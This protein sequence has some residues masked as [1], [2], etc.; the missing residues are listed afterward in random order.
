[1]SHRIKI[2]QPDQRSTATP[3]TGVM[4]RMVVARGC[5]NTITVHIDAPVF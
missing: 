1:M 4:V 5:V 2:I 3:Q